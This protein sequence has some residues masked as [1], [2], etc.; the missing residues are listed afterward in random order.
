MH[1]SLNQIIEKIEKVA[2]FIQIGFDKKEILSE[3]NNIKSDCDRLMLMNEK[4][5]SET[6]LND[7]TDYLNNQNQLRKLSQAVEQS[8][9]SVV[10]TDLNGDIEYVN[11]KF[12]EVTGYTFEESI[13][14]N[15]RILKSEA[16]SA[17]HYK[18]LWNKIISGNEW[19]GEFK[20][21]KKNGEIFWEMANLSA[22]KNAKGEITHYLALKENITELKILTDLQQILMSMASKYINLKYEDIKPSIDQS[23]GE[24][25]KFVQAQRALIFEYDW[26]NQVCNNTNEWCEEG[27]LAYSNELQNLPLSDMKEWVEMHQKGNLFEIYDVSLFKGKSKNILEKKNV[28][29]LIAIPLMLNGVCEGYI[30]FDSLTQKRNYTDKEKALLFVFCQLYINL[31]QRLNLE[32][33]LIQEKENAQQANIAKSEFLANM[34]HELRTPLNGIIGFSDLLIQTNLTEIQRQYSEAINI[35]GN[36]LNAVI[37]D[38]LD[39]SKIESNRFELEITK[40]NLHT[41][42]QQ[43]IDMLKLS[44]DKKGLEISLNIQQDLPEFIEIDQ[45]RLTQ[46]LTNLLGNAIKFTNKG[47]VE[48][49]VDFQRIENEEGLISFYIKDTGIGIS[50]EQ[51]LKLFKA[52]SQGDSSTTRRFGGTGLGLIVSNLIA[53][54]M[55]STILIESEIEKGSTF[56]FSIRTKISE[57]MNQNLEKQNSNSEIFQVQSTK[58]KIL[59]A[60]DDAFNMLLIK[61]IINNTSPLSEISEA[62]NGKVAFEMVSKC[63]FDIIFMDL[64]M[65][66]MDGIT[67]TKK[68]RIFEKQNE[69]YTPIIGLTASVTVEDKERCYQAG[70]DNVI[71][72]PIDINQLNQIIAEVQSRNI[73]NRNLN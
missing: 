66:E 3:L 9:I 19:R 5:V 41:I 24:I 40:V 59:I 34:S 18:E 50:D 58:L 69:C 39:F 36:I 6:I 45:V 7:K 27:V 8:P 38:I 16:L 42:L 62:I 20:N 10:I 55:G 17:E 46:I 52:F 35:S 32:N 49:K 30:G 15:P 72:K 71:I 63:S 44:A 70:M 22:I 48:L 65:P 4:T 37:N 31:K 73:T 64:Q 28:K 1:N 43:S 2:E 25:S 68:I 54:K 26:D 57:N 14:K 33:K 12:C 60:E 67:S 47:T 53:Q 21:I 23:L 11:P 51:K 56:Y 29:S 13:G 61:A